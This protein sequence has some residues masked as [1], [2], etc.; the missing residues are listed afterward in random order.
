[1]FGPNG[2]TTVVNK[3]LSF[4]SVATLS[5]AS[6]L[7]V[8]I[9]SATGI[10]IYGLRVV[11]TKTDDLLSLVGEGIKA[12][13]A[14][15][16]ALP[17]ALADGF[18]DERSPKYREQVDVGV[19]LP[20]QGNHRWSEGRAIIEVKNRG[21]RTITLMS[22]RVIGLDGEGDPV[23]ERPAWAATP[24]QIE[25]EWRG[26]ILPHETRQFAVW[27]HGSRDLA[28]VACEI[29]DLRLWKEQPSTPAATEQTPAQSAKDE[30]RAT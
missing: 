13:P 27:C 24:L 10:G 9:L 29:T 14:V 2:G 11:N 6:V 22:L 23:L 20:Q 12:L 30:H 26:P 17:P 19:R 7:I 5:V 21:D 28:S 8:A 4:L 16:A 1:M 3:R 15:R 25:G 18:D